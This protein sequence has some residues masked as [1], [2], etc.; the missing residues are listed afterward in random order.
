MHFKVHTCF[1]LGKGF[2]FSLHY[3]LLK[4][5]NFLPLHKYQSRYSLYLSREKRRAAQP[6]GCNHTMGQLCMPSSQ[7]LWM[8]LSKTSLPISLNLCLIALTAVWSGL[9]WDPRLYTVEIT[10]ANSF[11]GKYGHLSK[12]N[13]LLSSKGEYTP[14]T[15]IIPHGAD[16]HGWELLAVHVCL[17][18]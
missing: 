12:E 16:L 2:V 5:D 15:V 13:G 1:C 8:D 11:G 6:C 10:D 17:R 14:V 9:S 3:K 4:A 7:C 18:T